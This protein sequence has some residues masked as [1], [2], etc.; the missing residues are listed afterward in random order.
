MWLEIKPMNKRRH[1]NSDYKKRDVKDLKDMVTS[2]GKLYKTKTA[3]LVKNKPEEE[4]KPIT[5]KRFAYDVD[6]LGTSFLKMGLSGKKIAVIGDNSY[7]WAVTYFATVNGASVIVPIDKDL[8]VKEITNI[9][10]KAQVDAIVYSGKMKETIFKV[11]LEIKTIKH[12]INKSL[13]ENTK[14]EKSWINLVNAGKIDLN[15]GNTSFSEIVIDPEKM[16]TILFTS[17]TMG[18]AKGV[19]LSHKNIISNVY[20]LSKYVNVEKNYT[21]LSVLPMHHT[22]EM[23]AHICTAL[24]QGVGI[25]I[26]DG[27]KYIQPNLQEAKVNIML[28]VPLIFEGMHKK[29]MKKAETTG[30]LKKW[31]QLLTYPE[32]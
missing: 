12:F 11:G 24:Y 13:K 15:V 17:G 32:N 29:I 21:S 31:K 18:N 22:Y 8:T 5:Y 3:F 9:L 27:L 23:T 28:G 2:S 7:E 16:C 10:N 25:A 6:A 30:K 26:C 4:Y 14:E 1:M 19:M 20:N